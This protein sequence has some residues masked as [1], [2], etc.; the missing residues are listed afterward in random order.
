MASCQTR[1]VSSRRYT[2]HAAATPPRPRRTCYT[3][4]VNVA[5]AVCAYSS[6]AKEAEVARNQVSTDQGLP[7]I[8]KRQPVDCAPLQLPSS[9]VHPVFPSWGPAGWS[10]QRNARLGVGLPCGVGK[11]RPFSPSARRARR[12]PRLLHFLPA[13]LGAGTGLGSE[14][15]VDPAPDHYLLPALSFG[16]GSSEF[17]KAA[18]P[19]MNVE[20]E[21]SRKRTVA[22]CRVQGQ[23]RVGIADLQPAVWGFGGTSGGFDPRI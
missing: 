14:S 1:Y 18:Y 3:A 13:T 9:A 12:S 16:P 23:V 20:R 5:A 8:R 7:S 17:R 10:A 4:A 6:T 2:A 11:R 15:D 22:I 19:N 21:L